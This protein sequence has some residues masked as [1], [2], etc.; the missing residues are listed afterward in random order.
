MAFRQILLAL[1]AATLSASL[2]AEAPIIV[3]E[4]PQDVSVSLYRDP[5]RDAKQAMN[6][7]REDDDGMLGGYAMI[8]ETRDI[9]IPPGEVTLRF[10]GVASGILPQSAIMFNADPKEKNFDARLLSQRGLIDAFSGQAVEI[11]YT[12]PLT[13]EGKREMATIISQPDNLVLKTA[14][15]YISARCDGTMSTLLYNSKP[16]D[17]TAKP[18]L[19]MLT[20]ANNPGGKM[21]VTLVY[22]AANF[23]WQANYVATFSQDGQ[24]LN[25]AGWMTLA[26]KD[27]TSFSKAEVSAIAGKVNRVTLSDEEQEALDDERYN[28]PYS[29]YNIGLEYTCWPKGRT[30]EVRDIP[31]YVYS[32][33]ASK[34]Y[35]M[36]GEEIV[37]TAMRMS[38]MD[39]NEAI[40]VTGNRIASND[41]IGDLKLYT[42]PFPSDIPA[43]SIKQ[44]RFLR[45][46]EV[47]GETLYHGNYMA[48]DSEGDIELAFRFHNRKKDGAGD[49]LPAGQIALF[50]QS[51]AGRQL[52]GETSIDDK[53]VEEEVLVTLPQ[54][55]IGVDL[56]SDT[57]DRE[58]ED[59]QEHELTASNEHEWPVTVE[60]ELSENLS[61]ETQYRIS[62]FSKKLDRKDGKYI[63]RETI[64]A[65]SERSI[66]FRVTESEKS[67]ED[68][69]LDE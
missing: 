61:Y 27:K 59:W 64:P 7:D 19:S 33:P 16:A 60:V 48:G 40:A 66:R 11:K 58:G 52:L 50:Q 6:V 67:L 39:S 45:E 29:R 5:N 44:V 35:G 55:D 65:L 69:A 1:I 68:E 26:S 18:T 42:I 63:W 20:R 62:R 57:T 14:G 47:K 51:G 22:L 28:N 54:D 36:S 3:S 13:G 25:L 10:E 56:D 31:I 49:P 43:Q 34:Q 23:D 21:R 38:N 41:D 2:R 24:S 12:N 32:P 46:R 8:V 9:T 15:G 17:L 4:G 30:H 37:V 53:A